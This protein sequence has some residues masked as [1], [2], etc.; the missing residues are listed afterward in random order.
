LNFERPRETAERFTPREGEEVGV[1]GE[2]KQF[3]W[4]EKERE[5]VRDRDRD[6]E[7]E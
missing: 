4:I 7:K 5:W 6:R 2:E 3:R 1:G